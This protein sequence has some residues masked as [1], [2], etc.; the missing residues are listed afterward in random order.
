MFTDE[1]NLMLHCKLRTINLL[2]VKT[3]NHICNRFYAFLVK[4]LLLYATSVQKNA[5]ISILRNF[6]TFFFNFS[7]EILPRA[8]FQII[9]IIQTEITEGDGF[10]NLQPYKTCKK[11]E[12]FRVNPI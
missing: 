10:C 5:D 1:K 8:K 12:I 2:L 6:P 11:P 4:V 3:K 7:Q 9:W